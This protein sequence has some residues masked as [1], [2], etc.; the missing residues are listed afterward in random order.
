MISQIQKIL[1]IQAYCRRH[2]NS[3][4]SKSS[5]KAPRLF[6]QNSEKILDGCKNIFELNKKYSIATKIFLRI[7]KKIEIWECPPSL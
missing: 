6:T 1:K 3:P 5:S 4:I 7:Q 2:K